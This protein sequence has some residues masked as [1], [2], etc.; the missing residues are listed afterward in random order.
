MNTPS[1]QDTF[2]LPELLIALESLPAHEP[3]RFETTDGLDN[4]DCTN[5]KRAGFTTE[6]LAAF[7]K[8]CHMN[9]EPDVAAADLICDLLHFVHSLDFKPKEV[10]E[11]A[12]TNFIAEAG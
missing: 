4:P 2:Y 10:L 8:A 11:T 1:Q 5:A 6:A 7:Q 12:L 9:E 3:T